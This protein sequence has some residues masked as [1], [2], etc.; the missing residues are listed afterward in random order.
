MVKGGKKKMGVDTGR[1]VQLVT[2][3][4]EFLPNSMLSNKYTTKS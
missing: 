3:K 2:D 4:M 1:S